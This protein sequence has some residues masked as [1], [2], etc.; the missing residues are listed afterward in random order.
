MEETRVGREI[1]ERGEK[2][3]RMKECQEL[4]RRMVNRRFR[5]VPAWLDQW[6]NSQ[7]MPDR[8]EE[9]IESL[10]EVTSVDELRTRLA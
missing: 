3:G 9:I 1:M 10:F 2:S 8:V 4:L 6:L 7:T 5:S